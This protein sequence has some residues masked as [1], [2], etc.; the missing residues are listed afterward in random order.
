MKKTKHEPE[1]KEVGCMY[2]MFSRHVTT[3]FSN[4]EHG[5]SVNSKEGFRWMLS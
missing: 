1:I 2:R 3:L 5:K 4:T